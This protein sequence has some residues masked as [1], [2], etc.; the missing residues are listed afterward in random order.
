MNTT[1]LVFAWLLFAGTHIGM[2]TGRLRTSLVKKLGEKGFMGLYSLIALGTFGLLIELYRSTRPIGPPVLV[3]GMRHPAV[4]H[5]AELLMIFALIFLFTGFFNRTPMGMIS[6]TKEPKGI[7]RITRHPMNMAFAIYGF[8]H[9]MTNRMLGD[10]IFFGGFILFAYLGSVYQDK[11]KAEQLADFYKVTS[12][13]PFAAILGGRQQ[14]KW[15]EIS[16]TGTI[17]G[18]VAA[19]GIRLL[20]PSMSHFLR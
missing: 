11:K 18:I 10:W 3:S 12:I 14:L 17:I 9:L 15:R 6:G 20:H 2:S 16:K 1:L 5:S 8:T 4:V 19:L 13:I 7:V